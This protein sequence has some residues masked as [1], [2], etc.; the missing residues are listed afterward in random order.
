MTECGGYIA[1][2]LAEKEGTRPVGCRGEARA[3]SLGLL[4]RPSPYWPGSQRPNLSP[5]HRRI[6]HEPDGVGLA[7]QG[8]NPRFLLPLA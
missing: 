7:N 6:D 8:Q 3:G 2:G 4:A 1:G 5:Q